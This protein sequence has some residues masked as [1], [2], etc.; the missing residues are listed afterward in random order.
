[1]YIIDTVTR[2]IHTP[3]IGREGEEEKERGQDISPS[4]DS[5]YLGRRRRRKK[6]KEKRIQS[7]MK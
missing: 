4:D 2:R 5:R 3:V 7:A 1:M 6:K